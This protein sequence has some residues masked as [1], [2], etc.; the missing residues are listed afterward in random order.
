MTSSLLAVLRSESSFTDE[1]VFPRCYVKDPFGLSFSALGLLGASRAQTLEAAS[2]LMN[3]TMM[4]MWIVSG[5]F[6]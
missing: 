6:L 1:P 5:V 3:M 2:G 4:P